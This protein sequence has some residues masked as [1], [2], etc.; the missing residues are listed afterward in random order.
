[1]LQS[2][3]IKNL[4]R[5]IIWLTLKSFLLY[6]GESQNIM[7]ASKLK[8]YCKNISWVEYIKQT[9]KNPA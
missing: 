7:L 6:P 8:R 5:L 3:F 2:I 1:M 4:H 9:I